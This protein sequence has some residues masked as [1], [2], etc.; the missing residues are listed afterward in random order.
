MYLNIMQICAQ[1]NYHALNAT[2]HEDLLINYICPLISK[3]SDTY[4]VYY[5]T[6][7]TQNDVTQ[8]SGSGHSKLPSP[9]VICPEYQSSEMLASAF[10]PSRSNCG[11]LASLSQELTRLN[12]QALKAV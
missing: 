7:Q 4:S 2:R 11:L 12:G 9:P 5:Q 6:S 8:L 1:V 3:G 10:R